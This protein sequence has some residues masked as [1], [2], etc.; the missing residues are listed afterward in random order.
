LEQIEVVVAIDLCAVVVDE[1]FMS[2]FLEPAE[3]FENGT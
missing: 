2:A 3:S 1:V